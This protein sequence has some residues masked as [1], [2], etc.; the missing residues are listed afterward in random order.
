M[1][2]KMYRTNDSKRGFYQAIS[3]LLLLAC[4]GCGMFSG[5]APVALRQGDDEALAQLPTQIGGEIPMI[6]AAGKGRPLKIYSIAFDGTYND[7]ARVANDE[8]ATIVAHIAEAIPGTIYHEG[9]GM[10]STVPN[11]VDAALGYSLRSVAETAAVKFLAQAQQWQSADPD[12]EIRVV[13]TG[14]SRGAATAR[15]FMNAVSR[16]WL[17]RRAT[18]ASPDARLMQPHFYAILYDTVAASVDDGLQLSLPASLDYLV[19]FVARDEPRDEFI[20]VLDLDENFS[21]GVRPDCRQAVQKSI[22]MMQVCMPGAHSDVG[23]SYKEGVGNLYL[24]LTDELLYRMGLTKS[25]C[26]DLPGN[27]YDG[28]LHD[29]RGFIHK[30]RGV[31]AVDK[32]RLFRTVSVIRAA[33]M[34]GEDQISLVGRHQALV[35]AEW[36]AEKSFQ[37]NVRRQ[38]NLTIRVRRSGSML[39]MSPD[40]DKWIAPESLQYLVEDGLRKIQYRLKPSATTSSFIVDDRMWSML[41]DGESSAIRISSLVS[42]GKDMIILYVND[43]K[44]SVIVGNAPASEE[45]NKVICKTA[46]DGTKTT[47]FPIKAWVISPSTG[48]IRQVGS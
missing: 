1:N 29:S 47:N 21:P 12:T 8:R 45:Q 16:G 22:R 39:W 32:T 11:P 17:A 46:D 10:H 28:G 15:H 3:A 14:F 42:A 23:A 44:A 24:S 48:T 5:S 31:D 7:R 43:I 4:A 20:P 38:E 34:T 2:K 30:L 26:S 18:M 19:H 6:S 13:V 40:V 35:T 36:E 9:A 37:R 27:T 25:N 41:K 33:A